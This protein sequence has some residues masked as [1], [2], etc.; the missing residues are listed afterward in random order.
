[1][2]FIFEGRVK[3]KA[4]FKRPSEGNSSKW[5]T[6]IYFESSWQ[7]ANAR[8]EVLPVALDLGLLYE[9]ML[10]RLMPV[11]RNAGEDIRAQVQRLSEIRSKE[12]EAAKIEARMQKEK[13]FNRKIE[14]NSTL[15]ELRKAIDKMERYVN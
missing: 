5:V 7:K 8:R 6:D 11:S 14:L 1:M 4:A 10:R 12:N 15:R 3:T 9:Q 2:S 13:Q